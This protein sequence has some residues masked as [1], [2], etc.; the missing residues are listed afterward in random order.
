M[1][2][3]P[4]LRIQDFMSTRARIGMVAEIIRSLEPGPDVRLLDVGGGTG[5]AADLFARGCKEVVVLEPEDAKADYG[6]RRRGHLTFVRS[7]AESIP[8]P[9]AYFDRAAALVSFHH[10][11]DQDRALGEIH[12]VLKP[13]GRVLFHEFDPESPRGRMN[14]FWENDVMGN[15]CRFLRPQELKDHVERHGFRDVSVAPALVGYFLTATK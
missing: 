5:A 14:R 3:S 2:D 10:I 7:G 4:F 8:F 13:S 6:E 12:R 9:D 15:G 11:Q 1:R